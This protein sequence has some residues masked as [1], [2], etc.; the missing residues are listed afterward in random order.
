MATSG[1]TTFNPSLIE[2]VEEAY[3]RAGL[4][5]ISG[6]DMKTAR[7]SLNFMLQDWANRGLNLWTLEEGTLSLTQG[8]A[9][10]ALPTDTVDLIEMMLRTGTGT[11]QVDYNLTRVSTS[12]YASRTNKLVRGRPTEVYVQRTGYVIHPRVLE[13]AQAGGRWNGG[14]HDAGYPAALLPRDGRW[15]CLSYR[16]EEDWCRSACPNTSGNLQGGV[17]QGRRFR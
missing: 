14:H 13:I 16:H 3:E 7:R 10:Y 9:T 11:D 15:S 12:T 8:T 4:E 5:L 1:T 6:Y 2:I 17:R